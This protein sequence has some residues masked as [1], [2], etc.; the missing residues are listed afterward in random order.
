[1][2]GFT[3]PVSA[4]S[5]PVTSPRRLR[6]RSPSPVRS[7]DL[8]ISHGHPHPSMFSSTLTTGHNRLIPSPTPSQKS[9]DQKIDVIGDYII[10]VQRQSIMQ[11]INKILPFLETLI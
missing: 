8:N 5:H 6:S 3:P 1:M 7:N 2:P 9:D 11:Y 4:I 10:L